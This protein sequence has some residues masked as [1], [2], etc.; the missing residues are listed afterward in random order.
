[1]TEHRFA[2]LELESKATVKML[3]QVCRDGKAF[4]AAQAAHEKEDEHRIGAVENDVR[5][6]KI[7]G[8]SA[9]ALI[10]LGHWLKV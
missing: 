8:K 3:T 1:M 6:I 5:W 4:R 10:G 2:R 9:L 7:I